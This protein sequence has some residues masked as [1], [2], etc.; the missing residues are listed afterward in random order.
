[1]FN[2]ILMFSTMAFHLSVGTVDVFISIDLCVCKCVYYYFVLNA[3]HLDIHTLKCNRIGLDF[4]IDSVD[5][6]V[7][8]IQ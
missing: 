6:L 7:L 1:M 3:V 5:N 2:L 8:H 4:Q